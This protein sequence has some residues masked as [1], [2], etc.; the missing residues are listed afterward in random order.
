MYSLISA[1]LK[2][3]WRLPNLFSKARENTQCTRVFLGQR[4]CSHQL[5]AS[6]LKAAPLSLYVPHFPVPQ[7]LEGQSLWHTGC[8][9]VS[10][11]QNQVNLP[12]V[13]NTV[14][15]VQPRPLQYAFTRTKDGVVS[16]G[17]RWRM[18]SMCQFAQPWHL[19]VK[20]KEIFG[21]G[22]L[23]STEVWLPLIRAGRC[24]SANMVWTIRS[25]SWLVPVRETPLRR[26]WS[27]TRWAPITSRCWIC[28]M[29]V[30]NGRS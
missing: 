23:L 19:L 27:T 4:Q 5:E 30:S 7:H 22:L 3:G 1:T 24:A 25:T 12:V 26:T 15:P 16:W 29:M 9:R 14:G 10:V 13:E 28:T 8:P 18:L 6:L 2:A 11:V 20:H 17:I 21:G